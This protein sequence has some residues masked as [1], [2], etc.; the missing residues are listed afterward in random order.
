MAYDKVV[1][2]AVLN[3]GLKQIADAIREK[4]GTSDV[5]AFP[6]GMAEAI[7]DIAASGGGSVAQGSITFDADNNTPPTI[8]HNLGVIPNLF[9][10]YSA[11]AVAVEGACYLKGFVLFCGDVSDAGT[12]I[13]ASMRTFDASS[14]KWNHYGNNNSNYLVTGSSAGGGCL[15]HT[16]NATSATIYGHSLN[17]TKRPYEQG[18]KTYKWMMAVI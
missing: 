4:G 1:D 11:D 13:G 2:S 17:A 15:V 8:Q 9:L 6:A 3:A 14:T 5:L 10:Y 16:V 18:G 12:Y 7:A